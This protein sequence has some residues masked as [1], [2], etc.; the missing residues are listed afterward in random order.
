MIAMSV[1]DLRK[2]F[3][4]VRSQ[5]KKGESFLIIHKSKPIASLSPVDD[6]SDLAE[7]IDHE[8]E[9]VALEDFDDEYLSK[10]EIAHYFALKD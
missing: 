8:S 2:K 6:S 4:V 3:P 1:K 7:V 9:A 10:E 5:L